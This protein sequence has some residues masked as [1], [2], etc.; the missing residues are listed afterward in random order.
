MENA[1]SGVLVGNGSGETLGGGSAGRDGSGAA[2]GADGWVG[3]GDAPKRG[4]GRPRKTEPR[5]GDDDSGGAAIPEFGLA[6]GNPG[7]DTGAG[8]G[9]GAGSGAG[10]G[11]S[12][13]GGGTR[14]RKK[15]TAAA[16]T[17]PET[18]Q[19]IA[20]LLVASHEILADLANEPDLKITPP[21]AQGL[22]EAIGKVLDYYVPK[23]VMS[24][25]QAALVGLGIACA[26]VYGPKAVKIVKKRKAR[27]TH[28]D[29][30]T[31]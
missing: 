26:A 9:A 10:A 5:S 24:D 31:L 12:N 16:I 17:A 7:S 29:V 28:G 14:G 4:R 3:T 20:F 18:V 25:G 13:G 23:L 6:G 2:G 1:N 27:R 19:Q 8:A 21:Q 22:A 15:K 30:E 11:A